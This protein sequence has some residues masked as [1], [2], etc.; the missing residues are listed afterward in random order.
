MHS[1]SRRGVVISA[2]TAA[3]AF[4][5]D[6]PIEFIGAANAQGAAGAKHPNGSPQALIDKGFVKFKIGDI[7]VTQIYDGTWEKPHDPGF[8]RNASVDET[9]TALVA[10]GMTDAHMPIP[11][12]VTVA[13]IGNNT[14]MFDSGTGAQAAPTAGLI[15]TK[16]MLKTAGIDAASI[17]SI[18][19]THFHPDH[20][21]GLMEKDTNAQ[22]FPNAEIIVPV[23][24]LAYWSD[25]AATAKLPEARQPLVKRIQATIAT[26]KNVKQVEAGKDA[27]AGVRT[28]AMP[29]HTPGH[30]VYVM[31]SGSQQLIVSGD[32][33]NVAALFVKN[34]GW[35]AVFDY[36]PAVAEASRKALFDR[37][38]TDGA[39]ITGYHWGLPGAGTLKKDGNGYALVPVAV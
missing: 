23:G 17:K 1:I 33:S 10:A 25:A 37:A 6:K 31:G 39:V 21:F 2:A 24:E 36:E 5:L 19:V 22:V 7:E 18:L 30:A 12:T 4:G 3:A 28:L 8:I 35:H 27:V 32:V 11:F 16:D 20:I 26:W 13:K 15:K 14:I 34:P 9:K 38:V 29:G